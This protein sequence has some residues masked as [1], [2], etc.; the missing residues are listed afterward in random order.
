MVPIGGSH[1]YIFAYIWQNAQCDCIVK[2][3][4]EW[5][6]RGPHS[7]QTGKDK[8]DREMEEWLHPRGLAIT[9]GMQW[10]T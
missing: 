3:H 4:P 2:Y 8:G 6:A 1:I 10:K 9:R 5:P 7:K